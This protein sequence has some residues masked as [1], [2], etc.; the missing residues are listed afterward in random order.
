MP[1]SGAF[2]IAKPFLWMAFVAFLVGFF[3]YFL[4]NDP[5]QPFG[6]QPE[7]WSAAVSGPSSD[8]WNVLK[9]I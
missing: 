9:H 7:A 5:A 8:E 4:F 2:E 6:A 3:S 1:T